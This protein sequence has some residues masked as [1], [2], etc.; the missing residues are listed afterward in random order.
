MRPVRPPV[1]TDIEKL[2]PV[3]KLLILSVLALSACAVA[4]DRPSIPSK[5][6]ESFLS[7]KNAVRACSFHAP[8][9]GKDAVG[10]NYVGGLMINGLSG[11]VGTAMNEDRIRARGE[12]SAVDRCL[13]ENGFDRRELSEAEEAALN[14]SGAAERTALL[15]HLVGG[16]TLETFRRAPQ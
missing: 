10:L 5:P 1:E 11:V 3:K 15:D 13:R 16:G 8:Q 4:A 7:A 6:G 14:R 2:I 12:V 9:G